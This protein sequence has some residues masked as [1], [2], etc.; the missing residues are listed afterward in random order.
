MEVGV[1]FSIQQL[2][3]TGLQ[4]VIQILSVAKV[5]DSVACAVQHQQR[6]VCGQTWHRAGEVARADGVHLRCGGGQW[7]VATFA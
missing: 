3:A 5:H 2:S 1:V 7:P 6:G 4:Q